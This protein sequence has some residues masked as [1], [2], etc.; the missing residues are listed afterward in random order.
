MNA[1]LWSRRTTAGS[2]ISR[3]RP[4]DTSCSSSGWLS[5]VHRV[6][7]RAAG[8]P[9]P[10]GRKTAPSSITAPERASCR[11]AFAPD[12]R[13]LRLSARSK[14]PSIR[15]P[16]STPTTTWLATDACSWWR[17]FEP[18][19]QKFGSSLVFRTNWPPSFRHSDKP[20]MDS[21][22]I[23]LPA[24]DAV[25]PDSPVQ[26]WYWT[27]HLQAR[28]GRRFGFE[29]CFFAIDA[30]DDFFGSVLADRLLAHTLS[31]DVEGFQVTH[32]AL[33][34]VTGQAFHSRVDYILGMPR[35]LDGS[36]DLGS[37]WP[38]A[39][40]VTAAGGNGSDRLHGEV[41]GRVF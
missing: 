40:K 27:G 36:F 29:L 28:D 23:A 30:A 18:P 33:T 12:L 9:S 11:L 26:W 17:R 8:R 32:C 2:R 20:A 6:S 31:R 25:R 3:M 4:A 24:D 15:I 1:L 22:R 7:F 38:V 21:M 19:D 14:D 41:D 13:W 35:P 39:G 34:E 10:H 16:S 37:E 5:R